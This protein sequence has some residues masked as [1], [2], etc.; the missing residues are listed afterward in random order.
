MPSREGIT[1]ST[2]L[3]TYL[4][5]AKFNKT[6]V[7]LGTKYGKC[8]NYETMIR[9]ETQVRPIYTSRGLPVTVLEYSLQS[10]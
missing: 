4:L 9:K 7:T 3:L 2:Y 8:A 5:I 6:T 10:L 1:T